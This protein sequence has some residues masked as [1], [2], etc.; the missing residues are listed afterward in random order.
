ML[1]SW[2]YTRGRGGQGGGRLPRSCCQDRRGQDLNWAAIT[3]WGSASLGGFASSSGSCEWKQA[4]S[5][6]CSPR[7]RGRE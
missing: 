5:R 4:W 7:L 6:P 3:L 2:S 1:L